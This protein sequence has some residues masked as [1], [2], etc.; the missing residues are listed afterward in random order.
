MGDSEPIWVPVAVRSP[1]NNKAPD[2]AGVILGVYPTVLYEL[3]LYKDMIYEPEHILIERL[4]EI[5]LSANIRRSTMSAIMD[6]IIPTHARRDRY[7]LKWIAQPI[8]S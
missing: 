2:A 7:A 3:L 8:W 1:Y 4:Y 6:C 5:S